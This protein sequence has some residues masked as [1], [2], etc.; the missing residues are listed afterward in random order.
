MASPVWQTTAGLLGVINER[1]FYSVTLSATDAD[2]DSL[3]YSKI[4]GTL[5]TG[6]E[7]TSGGVLQGVPTEV[8]TRTLYTFVVR[9]SD[10][11][12]VADRTF[13]LQIQGADAPVFATAAGELNLADSTQGRVNRWVLDGSL[14]NFQLQAT[15][16]DTAAGQTLRFF[17]QEG[18]LP[19][20]LTLAPDGKITGTVLLTDDERYGP[21]GGYDDTYAYDDVGYDPTAFSTSISKN[22][23]FTVGVT[24]G[25][26]VTTQINSI[27]VFSA[28]YWLV[29]NSQITIDS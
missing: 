15:D 14:V 26:N 23:E 21:I 13:S 16:T 2:G 9:A 7:L 4:A 19:P 5:P 29:S 1:D 18:E 3:T 10:G 25:S 22:F 6:I 28:D 8:A 27:F 17:I 24:D 11:T 12:N 20:G